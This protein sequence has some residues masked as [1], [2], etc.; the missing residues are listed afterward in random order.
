MSRACIHLGM[1]N[2]PISDGICQE[3]LDTISGLISQQ[4][5]KTPT[6]PMA[7]SKEFLDKYVIHSGPRPKKMLQGHELEDVLDKFEHLSSP[8]L[9]NMIS[10]CKS[11]GKR[12]AYD[13]IMAM[14]MYTTV[15]YIHANV[16][17]GQGKYKE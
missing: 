14:K 6:I 13:N 16:C 8:N 9:Q 11:C 3:T 2:Y 7:A 17:P 4:V 1:H 5:S 12:G 10:L 15:E